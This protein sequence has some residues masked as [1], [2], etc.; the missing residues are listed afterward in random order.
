M[1]PAM[2]GHPGVTS[3]GGHGVPSPLQVGGGGG[4][5]GWGVGVGVSSLSC[6][7]VRGSTVYSSAAC[8]YSLLPN[9]QVFS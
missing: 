6:K 2:A 4:G 8:N 5:G 7:S 3:V 9:L 1:M